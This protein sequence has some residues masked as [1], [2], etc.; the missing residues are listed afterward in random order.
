MKEFA[1]CCCWCIISDCSFDRSCWCFQN[2]CP[3]TTTC[4]T[5]QGLTHRI[6]HTNRCFRSSSMSICFCFVTIAASSDGTRMGARCGLYR[7]TFRV[8]SGSLYGLR[9]GLAWMCLNRFVWTRLATPS[10][11]CSI[12]GVTTCGTFWN[13]GISTFS[14]FGMSRNLN[15]IAVT[16]TR[17]ATAPNGPRNQYI[18]WKSLV[19]SVPGADVDPHKSPSFVQ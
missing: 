7:S 5:V 17:T 1:S 12:V 2:S 11:M 10:R 4:Y 6:H 15:L 18:T 3:H 8:T 14:P 16:H 9:T 19:Q 13:S